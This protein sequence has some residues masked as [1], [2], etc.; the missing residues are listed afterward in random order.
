M[1][2]VRVALLSFAVLLAAPA[3]HARA[4]AAAPSLSVEQA[5]AQQRSDVIVE[6]TG[7][8]DR[9][10]R[11]DLKGRRH[12]RFIVALPSGHTVLIAHNIELAA[13]VPLRVGDTVTIHGE[14]EW[15]DKGGVI[16]W[17]H[18]DPRGVRPGGWIRH[19]KKL[20]R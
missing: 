10:L 4:P 12:Q 17:T 6:V 14:Y 19:D 20:Y 8:V 9:V 7:K 16:H 1:T 5:Y 11:D 2:F 13:R 18:H 15:S 3:A